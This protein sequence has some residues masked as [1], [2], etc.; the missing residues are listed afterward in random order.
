MNIKQ[1]QIK[2]KII[3]SIIILLVMFVVSST[4]C[5]V[6]FSGDTKIVKVHK[7][8]KLLPR[9]ATATVIAIDGE[10][11]YKIYYC[12]KQVKLGDDVE[13]FSLSLFG[14]TICTSV[15]FFWILCCVIV[16]IISV[17]GIWNIIAHEIFKGIT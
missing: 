10:V 17:F 2:L 7:I 6:Y 14:N 15:S 13:V 12:P 4:T 8:E 5:I 3:L 9:D 1:I 11:Q 16:S